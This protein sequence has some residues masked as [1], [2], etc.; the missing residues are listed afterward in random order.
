LVVVR[1]SPFVA[2]VGRG[3]RLGRERVDP[4]ARRVIEHEIDGCESVV[5]LRDAP[6]TEQDRGDE[7][8]EDL[9][10]LPIRRIAVTALVLSRWW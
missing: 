9:G 2:A 4:C 3:R 6:D 7:G 8:R 10:R 5:E 1:A